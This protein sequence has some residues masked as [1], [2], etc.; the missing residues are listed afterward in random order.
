MAKRRAG[1]FSQKKHPTLS[2]TKTIFGTRSLQMLRDNKCDARRPP[3]PCGATMRTQSQWSNRA[4]YVSPM[5]CWNPNYFELPSAWIGHAPFAFWLMGAHQPRTVVELG[6]HGGYSYFVFCQAALALGLDTKCYAVDTW[7]GDEHAGFYGEEI[8]EHVQNYNHRHY[9]AFSHLLRSTFDEALH[10]F[11]DGSIDLLHIDGRH[12]YEDVKHDFESWRPKLSERSIV[13]LHDTN[14]RDK[15]FGVFR[16]WDEIW[17]EFSTFEYFHS[18]GLGVVGFGSSLPHN[19]QRFFVTTKNSRVAAQA[20]Q[21]YSYLGSQLTRNVAK[22]AK[23]CDGD[24]ASHRNR[25]KK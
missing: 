10:L 13:L 22:I 5:S 9:S 3:A 19:V 16:L 1:N 15:D 18:Y 23:D 8:F 12:L 7:K 21:V 6:T 20:R 24:K 4:A 11:N 25:P 2:Q 14:V 17:A